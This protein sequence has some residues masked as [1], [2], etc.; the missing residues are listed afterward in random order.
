MNKFQKPFTINPGVLNST[1]GDPFGYVS[2][3]GKWAAIPFGKK[4]VIIHNGKQVHIE[5]NYIKSKSYIL[6]QIK[7]EITTPLTEYFK[8]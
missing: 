2:K 1:T 3:D 6:K 5:N 4:F 8:N 7:L